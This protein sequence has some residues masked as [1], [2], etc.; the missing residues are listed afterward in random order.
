MTKRLWVWREV[1]PNGKPGDYYEN[2]S[3]L[4]ATGRAFVMRSSESI[5]GPA[6]TEI[7]GV[8]DSYEAALKMVEIGNEG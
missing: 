6:E 2:M 5:D 7:L 8:F 4:T 3:K 1:V